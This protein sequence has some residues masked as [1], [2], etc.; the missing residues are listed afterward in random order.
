M[1]GNLIMDGRI[2][3]KTKLKLDK[4]QDEFNDEKYLSWNV[5]EINAMVYE[6]NSQW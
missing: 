1:F 3:Y 4:K 2:H 5:E 6:I